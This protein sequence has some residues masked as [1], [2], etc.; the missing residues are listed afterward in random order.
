MKNLSTRK[1]HK[2]PARLLC[3]AGVLV[4]ALGLLGACG[5][6]S[7]TTGSAGTSGTNVAGGTT[8]TKEVVKFKYPEWVYY[9]LVYL[10]DDLGYFDDAT[11]QPEYIGNVAAGDMIPALATGDLDVVTRHT[12]LVINAVAKGA[13]IKIFAA[14]S[15]STKANPHMK[16]FVTADSPIQGIEEFAGKTLGINSLGACSEFVTKKALQD[17]GLDPSSIEIITAPDS[18]QEEPLLKGDTDVAIIHPL[19]SGRATAN[20][21]D[22]RLLFSDW[23]IDGG[24][25]GMCPYSTSGTF[26]AEHPDAITELTEILS[27]AAQWNNEH[28]EEARQLMADHFGF[29]IEEAEMF[30]FF[31]DQIIPEPN[32]AYWFERLEAEGV[33]KAGEVKPADIYTNDFNPAKK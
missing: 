27:R 20:T 12:P 30:E 26:L 11:V 9:D 15:M 7:A 13:D 19:S 5:D 8:E 24:I 23:D 21:T 17:A 2:L 4:L 10:A 25:S 29:K 31:P 1:T 33:I 16:Y 3:F 22:F 32:I 18:A 28:P 6:N 14:G